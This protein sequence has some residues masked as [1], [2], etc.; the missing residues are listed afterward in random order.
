MGKNFPYAPAMPSTDEIIARL[1]GPE[2]AAKLTGVGLE[3]IRKWRQSR[4]I[5]SKHWPAIVAATGLPFTALT[6]APTPEPP[7]PRATSPGPHDAPPGATAALVLADG[8]AF[9]GRGFG[10]HTRRG[11]GRRGRVQH[12][13]D[14]ATRRR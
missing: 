3:A 8:T 1:G 2:A 12:R 9:W 10:A 13:H 6:G 11:A 5:P 14:A 7:M 4:A